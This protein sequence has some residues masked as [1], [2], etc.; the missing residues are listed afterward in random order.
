MKRIGNFLLKIFI[1]MVWFLAIYICSQM[2]Y[3]AF[4]LKYGSELRLYTLA[5]MV[6]VLGSSSLLTYTVFNAREKR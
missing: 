6:I 2:F 1:M 5:F 4:I 3:E